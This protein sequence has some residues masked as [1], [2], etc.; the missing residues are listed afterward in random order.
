MRRLGRRYVSNE[1]YRKLVGRGDDQL[2]GRRRYSYHEYF[3][4]GLMMY[5][6]R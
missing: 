6:I 1:L 4:F 3:N 5:Y 2:I